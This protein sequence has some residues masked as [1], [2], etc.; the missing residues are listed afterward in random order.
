MLPHLLLLSAALAMANPGKLIGK[1]TIH[2]LLFYGALVL[3]TW[4]C[5][6]HGNLIIS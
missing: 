5:S 4:S 1:Y 3:T 2:F 6:V